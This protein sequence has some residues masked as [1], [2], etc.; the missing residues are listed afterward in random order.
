MTTPP[1]IAEARPYR[2][3]LAD[4]SV[5]D[6]PWYWLRDRDDPA[7]LAYLEAENA[8]ADAWF[9]P[10]QPLVDEIVDEIRGRIQETDAS[11]PV[12]H[13]GWLY[14]HR[15][16]EGDAYPIH[17][18]RPAPDGV[19]DARDL[20]H[21]LRVAVDPEDPPADEVVLLDEN[22]EASDGEYFR[23]GTYV[24]SPD[25]RLAAEGVD[26]SGGEVLAIRFR[27]LATGELLDD[28]IERAGYGAA[29]SA[30]SASLL[31]TVTDDA[32][33]PYQVWRHTLGTPST[34]DVLVHEEEDERFWLGV[35]RFRSGR[36]LV[37][38]AG[39]KVTDEWWLIDAEDVAA[40]PRCVVERV[41]GVQVDVDHRGD[42]LLLL[43][44]ADGA[45]DFRLLAAD[46][47]TP[48]RRRVVLDH[49]PGVRLE[50]V[51]AF[52][53][54]LVVSERTEATTR[55]RVLGPDGAE[56][57][58]LDGGGEVST[59]VVGPNPEH[60]TRVLR[61][62]TTSLAEPTSVVDVDLD[63]GERFVAKRQPVRGGYEPDR[64]TAWRT[65]AQA[66][67]G[68]HV[69]ISLV[70]RDDALA[71]GPAPC[72]LYGYG[73]YELSMDPV[74]SPVRLSLLDRGVVFAIAHVRGGGEMGRRWYEQG[75]LMAKPNTFT[76]FVACADH[77]VEE[78]VTSYDRLAIR[79]GSAG[80]MLVGAVLNLRPDLC[81]AAVAEVPFVDVAATMSDPSLPL[82]VIEYDEWGDPRDPEV[83]AVM[84]RYSPV[85]NVRPAAYPALYVTA[86]LND[87]RVQY[88]EP[89]KWVARLRARA[90]ADAPLLLHTELGAGHGG[91]SGRYD[92][93][94]DE[95]RV[96][97]FVLDRLGVV[98]VA[99]TAATADRGDG[100]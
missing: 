58:V 27:D 52:A 60:R 68:E 84:R 24:V 19:R 37:I 51:D 44:N 55:V 86:G 74:F 15:T 95:A 100:D 77:L 21:R 4:G 20:P 79:G 64:Y 63:T 25:H 43:T 12:L 9:A 73:S 49:R 40:P 72:L 66:P 85:D 33:R 35:G 46:V 6:D 16:R 7:V 90:V 3:R 1:P 50:S 69:P 45:V 94:R 28:V 65:W 48:E 42:Q 41:E 30:D 56:S 18:R 5:V 88:W 96:L 71:A 38:H 67:D 99:T 34:D 53:D 75:R 80:G 57:V 82:T 93:W 76:D 2:A 29:F 70:A 39:S 81:A 89:A 8:H 59:A 17:V 83:M 47:A 26:R 31:Y 61:I 92:A 11:A 23:L 97:A 22:D 14:Y 78:S 13:G 87:P 36:Y 62:V 98:D 10:R 32:W 54:H 91:R